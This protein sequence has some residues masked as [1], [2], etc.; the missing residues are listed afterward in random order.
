MPLSKDDILNKIHLRQVKI[1]DLPEQSIQPA[2]VDLRLGDT[3]AFY[4]SLGELDLRSKE[5]YTMTKIRIPDTGYVLRPGD[6]VLSRSLESVRLSGDVSALITGRSTLGRAFVSVTCGADYLDPGHEGPVS[7]QLCNRGRNP[8]RIYSGMRVAQL[9]IFDV[10][11]GSS[12][13]Q[14]KY[15]DP[16][17]FGFLP[18]KET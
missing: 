1:D 10:A 12:L 13:Y 17:H 3:V 6:A 14:G 9:V 15:R 7:F 11:H 16:E 5:A 8:V 2:S 4:S 18:D